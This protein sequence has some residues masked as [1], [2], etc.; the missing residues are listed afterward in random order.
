MS[1]SP[2][3]S[4]N[5]AE[6]QPKPTV[7][8]EPCV[9]RKGNSIPT[10]AQLEGR[11]TGPRSNKR[12]RRTNKKMPSWMHEKIL[13]VLDDNGKSILV[14]ITDKGEISRNLPETKPM[15]DEKDK[16]IDSDTAGK[17]LEES[18]EELS[19]SEEA[20]S[21]SDESWKLADEEEEEEEEE[22]ED[23][24]TESD[25]EPPTEDSESEDEAEEYDSDTEYDEEDEEEEDERRPHKKRR[26][27]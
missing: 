5:P 27:S 20:P 4:L 8:A 16:D 7:V 11:S 23:P 10:L 12:P 18:D 13:E 9:P 14:Y 24:L 26:I 2:D 19:S 22:E 25:I 6:T 1:S 17:L 15:P 21:E 3:P